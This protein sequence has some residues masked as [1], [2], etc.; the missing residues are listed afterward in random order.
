MRVRI[1][2]GSQNRLW[3]P[4]SESTMVTYVRIDYGHLETQQ[5]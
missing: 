1:D 5:A 3:L 4:M 2:Y